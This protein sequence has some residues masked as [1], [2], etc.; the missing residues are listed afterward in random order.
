MYRQTKKQSFRDNVQVDQEFGCWI[1]IGSMHPKGYGLFCAGGRK[2]YAHRYLYE[3][4]NG[5][6]PPGLELDHLCE[7]KACVHPDHLEA[8]THAENMR[9]AAR[10]GVWS[11]ERN[12]NAKLSELEVVVIKK[13]RELDAPVKELARI[14]N[15]SVRSV[16]YIVKGESWSHVNP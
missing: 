16:F 15:A 1:W 5:P 14:F 3:Y 11:G 4:L 6:V 12:P 7:N 9:R 2:I 13:A 10:R 8:V